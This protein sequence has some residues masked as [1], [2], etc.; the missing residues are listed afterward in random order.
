LNDSTIFNNDLAGKVGIE[1]A[2]LLQRI[3]YF[4]EHNKNTN[5]NF[6]DGKYWF[7]DTAK[8]FLEKFLFFKSVKSVYR[9]MKQL[10]TD[11]WILTGNYNE[12]ANDTTKWYTYGPTMLE[13]LK[14]TASQN[15]SLEKEKHENE[16][17]IDSQKLESKQ[18]S[19]KNTLKID[20]QNESS[21]YPKTGVGL[22]KS[23]SRSATFENPFKKALKTQDRHRRD[24]PGARGK[25][26]EL[27][28]EQSQR[29]AIAEDDGFRSETFKLF[30]EEYPKK[31]KEYTAW[32]EWLNQGIDTKPYIQTKIFESLQAFKLCEEWG[33]ETGR[34]IPFAH[35]WLRDRRYNEFPEA[36]DKQRSVVEE[37][38]TKR[39]GVEA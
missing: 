18:E 1:K 20:S 23:G 17:K 26:F 9:W 7:Y 24:T 15:E 13:Y 8:A 34:Y 14:K 11:G 3:F 12:D 27:V 29:N 5:Q 39:I 6:H 30:L 4:V 19:V 32:L 16:S 22:P 25:H 31:E 10:E 2:I 38:Q 28:P 36:A 37:H 35:N 21:D 33:K